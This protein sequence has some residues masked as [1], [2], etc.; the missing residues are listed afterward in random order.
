VSAPLRISARASGVRFAVR[1][2][3]RASRS[4]IAGI[5]DGAL[6]VRLAAPPVDG[7]ANDELVRVIS[8]ALHVPP[9]AVRIA[10]GASNRSKTVD[11][12]GV[13]VATAQR[14]LAIPVE[15]S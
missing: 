14:S 6:K 4:Q 10:T 15:P 11:V 13:D 9:S 2:V 3:V 8:R 1:V 12:A 5:H 7:A